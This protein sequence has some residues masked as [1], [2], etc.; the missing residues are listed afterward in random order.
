M[1]KFVKALKKSES[2]SKE[3]SPKPA[4]KRVAKTSAETV[5]ALRLHITAPQEPALDPDA[6]QKYLGAYERPEEEG[7]DPVQVLIHNGRLAISVPEVDTVLELYPPDEEGKWRM[8]MNPTVAISFQEDE[9]GN[10]VSFTAHTPEG[11]FVRPR[12]E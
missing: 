11:D 4:P 10:V 1:G 6:V 5:D 2:I 7:S 8:R 12:V 9:A 3:P